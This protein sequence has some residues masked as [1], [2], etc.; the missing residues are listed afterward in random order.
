MLLKKYNS[1][2]QRSES[3]RQKSALGLTLFCSIII[4]VS[5]GFYKGFISFG[6]AG[7]L[8]NEKSS[9]NVANVVSAKSVPSPIENS[10]ETFKSSF[11]DIKKQY[12]SF[13]DSVSAVFVPF[14][15]GIEVYQR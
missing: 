4:F 11:G 10:K 13:K 2:M 1:I 9:N 6:N 3:Y 14:I 8:A 5:F 15:T 12:Q 7:T